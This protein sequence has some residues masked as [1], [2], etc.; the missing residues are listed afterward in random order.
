MAQWVSGLCSIIKDENDVKIKNHMLTYVS[1]LMEDCHDFGWQ[2]AKGA[3]AVVLCQMEENKVNWQ[4]TDRLDRIRRVHAQRNSNP[5]IQCPVGKRQKTVEFHVN[6]TKKV[7]VAKKNEH[8]NAGQLY[9]HVCNFCF[10]KGRS[11][12]HPG[13][14]C[15]RAKKTNRALQKCS[16]KK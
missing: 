6:F 12:P 15:R 11:N 16:A 3:H 8:E 5:K 2:S 1:D 4:D 13:K 7:R 14:D 9:L 10:S